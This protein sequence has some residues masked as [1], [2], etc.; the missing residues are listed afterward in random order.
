M[1]SIT[2]RAIGVFILLV[3]MGSAVKAQQQHTDSLMKKLTAL[4]DDYVN[5]IK[6][7]GYTP[8]LPPPEIVIDNPRSFGNYDE[9]NVL[10]TSDW[11]TLPPEVHDIFGNFAKNIGNGMTAEK[12]FNLAVYQWIFVHE[13]GHWWRT[14]QH[15]EAD[16]YQEEKGANRI[17]SAYWKER[18]PA[19]YQLMLGVFQGVIA[20][21]PSPVPAGVSKEQF[22]KDNYDKL[23]GGADYSW[24]Q[25]IM[26]IE[27]SKENPFETFKQAI[28]L[29]GKP[30]NK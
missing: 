30:L 7:L 14:C 27:V 21:H 28:Q 18:D 25:S 4:R 24:Y 22:L 13:L 12:F 9:K 23:P 29:A 20:H 1:T 8:S 11:N 16:P 6:A 26:I 17:A 10:H 2:R 19:F 15:I 5:K 3:M